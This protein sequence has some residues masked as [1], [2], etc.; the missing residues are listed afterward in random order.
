MDDKELKPIKVDTE[1][2]ATDD[3]KKQVIGAAEE[4]AKLFASLKEFWETWIPGGYR[5]R[6]RFRTPGHGKRKGINRRRNRAARAMRKTQ[7]RKKGK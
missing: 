4:Q 7:R 3:F 2:S 6:K 1:V 5:K